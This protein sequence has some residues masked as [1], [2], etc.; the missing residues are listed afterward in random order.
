MASPQKIIDVAAAVITRPDG[1]FLLA[2]RPEGKP[3]PG[4]WEFPG[5]KLEPG[6]NPQQA[7]NRELMEE[8]GLQVEHSYPWITRVFDYEHATVRLHFYRVV[9]WHGEPYPHEGQ[10]LSWQSADHVDVAPML[11]AN[12]SVLKSLTLPSICAITNASEI[13]VS[14]SL[15]RIERALLKGVRLIQIR[16]KG[17]GRDELRAFAAGVIDRSHQHGAR[18]L[19]NGDLRMALEVGANGLHLPS[20]DLMN[21][22]QRPDIGWCSASCHNSEELFQAAQMGMDLVLL[23]P[24]LPT[25]SHPG[26]S[27]LGWQRFAN[28]IRDYPVPVYALGGMREEDMNTSCEHGGHG[29]AMMRGFAGDLQ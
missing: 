5:G 14:L 20:S 27:S 1:R 18:V 29:I 10:T 22:T 16:E 19:L 21:L 24:V 12:A 26:S 7:L 17:M 3:Y 2:R 13:G 28:L 8:L 4:Y 11:P 25:L 23:G 9:A 6:E 15:E